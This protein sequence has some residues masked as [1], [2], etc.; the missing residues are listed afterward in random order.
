MFENL[1]TLF[2]GFQKY[3]DR[4][5]YSKSQTVSPKALNLGLYCSVILL[6]YSSEQYL[7]VQIISAG[8]PKITLRHAEQTYA[9]Q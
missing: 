5:T 7:E 6:S 3:L 8:V 1:V 4:S 2:G 9:R